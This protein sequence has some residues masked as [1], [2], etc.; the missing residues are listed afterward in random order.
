[1]KNR[2]KRFKRNLVD[3]LKRPDM[4]ILPGQLAFFFILSIVPA[5]T[6][7]AYMVSFL[8]IS[9]DDFAAYFNFNISPLIEE[10]F[11]PTI[12]SLDFKFGSVI[13]FIIGIYIISNGTNSII[14]TADNIYSIK[15]S[16]FF[17]RR[18]KAILMVFILLMLFMFIIL[19]PILGNFLLSLIE[20]ITGYSNVYNLINLLRL[21]ISWLIVFLFIK[22]LYTVAPDKNI[23]SRH[24]NM[25]V[26]FTSILWMASTEIYLY[27]ISNFANYSLLYSGLAN[28]AVI[29]IWMYILSTIFVI[30][31]AIN[32]KEEPYELE[33]TR[34]QQEL[35]ELRNAK[36]SQNKKWYEE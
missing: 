12:G 6:L 34:E 1:M 21:P 10:F 16:S 30:G 27:Y 13:I 11:I 32:Y 26:M 3:I 29:M 28:V 22:V 18:I 7:V 9:L 19:V 23:P 35:K 24:T 4:Q 17:R 33:K 31:L 20:R 36:K 2:L 5:L 8:S 14:V 25:G 15:P